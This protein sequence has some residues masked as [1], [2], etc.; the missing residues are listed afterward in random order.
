[1]TILRAAE[2]KALNKIRLTGAVIDL[3]GEKRSSYRSLVHGAESAT[4]VN[5]L[6]AAEPDIVADLEKPLPLADATYDAAL[7]VN[8]LEHVFEY[9]ALLAECARILRPAGRIVVVVPYLFPYHP[10]PHDFHR[11]S[12]E[13]LERALASAGFSSVQVRA[14]APGV[15]SARYLFIERLIPG[16]LQNFLAPLTH[17]LTRGMDALVGAIARALGKKYDPADY[18]LGFIVEAHK[19]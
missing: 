15:F 14:L 19:A 18:A 7:L 1:M 12:K 10:S 3:G 8:V 11:F 2:H 5:I 6:P 16:V 4:T 17:P 13:A 9:R